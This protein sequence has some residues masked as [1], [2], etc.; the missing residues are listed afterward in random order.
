MRWPERRAPQGLGRRE[1]AR[2]A[3][4]PVRDLDGG[5][6]DYSDPCAYPSASEDPCQSSITPDDGT[7]SVQISHTSGAA[8]AT[9]GFLAYARTGEGE[10][11]CPDSLGDDWVSGDDQWVNAEVPWSELTGKQPFTITASDSPS[12]AL[13]SVSRQVSITLQP[14]D[15]DGT[16]LSGAGT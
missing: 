4:R 2:A 7:L 6:V 5:T 10:I 14:V 9:V 11:A 3:R 1:S 12:D 8:D 13:R 16:P 15:V